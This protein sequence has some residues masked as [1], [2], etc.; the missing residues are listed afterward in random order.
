MFEV[1]YGFISAQKATFPED[2]PLFLLR[3]KDKL[4]PRAVRYY[5]QICR[6]LAITTKN[7]ALME[8]GEKAQ[9]VA[10]EMEHYQRIHAS[11]VKLPD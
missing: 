1:K 10:Q 11:R 9:V 6:H 8:V 4:A 3:A 5:A 2:E 7:K